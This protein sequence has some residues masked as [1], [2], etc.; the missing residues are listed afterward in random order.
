MT[1]TDTYSRK[2][3]STLILALGDKV[4]FLD[5]RATRSFPTTSHTHHP[6]KSWNMTPDPKCYTFLESSHQMQFISAEKRFFLHIGRIF[7]SDLLSKVRKVNRSWWGPFCKMS[8]NLYCHLKIYS[9]K[10]L[11]T[12]GQPSNPKTALYLPT[13]SLGR[14]EDGA[15]GTITFYLWQGSRSIFEDPRVLSLP[16]LV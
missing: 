8:K 15:K 12:E 3:K 11:E 16:T 6:P 5:L 1:T 7:F 13:L 2:E 4:Q 10:H 14:T 9:P